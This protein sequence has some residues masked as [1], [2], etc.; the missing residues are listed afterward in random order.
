MKRL[1]M[2]ATFAL[3]LSIGGVSPAVALADDS[4][5]DAT[6]VQA[7]GSGDAEFP[8]TE[9]PPTDPGE[10]AADSDD[11]ST[12]AEPGD[13]EDST[14]PVGDENAADPGDGEGPADPDEGSDEPTEDSAPIDASFSLDQST[15]PVDEAAEAIPYTITGLKAGDTV[16][17]SPGENGSITVDND[18][19]FNGELRGN[20]EL[21]VGDVVD[22]TVTVARDGQEPKTF[23]GNVEITENQDDSDASVS[24]DPQSQGIDSYLD[25]GVDITVSSC[26]PGEDVT[27]TIVR[28][29]EN[30]NI[31]E[32]T[33]TAGDDGS[34]SASF[35]PGTGGDGWIGEFVVR[36]KCGDTTAET[37]YS[38]TE[39]ED[40]D[41]ADLSITPQS[42]KL[43]VF[44]ENGVNITLVN[45]HV[46]SNVKFEVS[47]AKN[48][49]TVIWEE[50]QKAGE[51]AAGSVQFL[52]EGDGGTAW[53]G[54]FNVVAS[55][56]DKSAEATF[57]VTDDGSVVDPKLSISPE[58]IS[59]EDFIDRDQGV[60]LMVNKCVPDA[61]VNF[62][63]WSEGKKEKLYEQTATAN[64]EGAAGIH[65][66]GLGDDPAYYVG[67]YQVIAEC[68]DVS[69][70][71]EF[72]VTG[73]ESGGGDGGD[74]GGAGGSGGGSSMPRTGAELTGLA[75]GA[76]LILG[77]GTA[78]GLARRKNKS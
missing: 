55:C 14:D 23:T 64:E 29:G 33:K 53:V 51:D 34:V 27:V 41:D 63:V 4:S 10:D 38:V 47:S 68:M 2:A 18:G 62:E 46:D 1:A 72:V 58:T 52:P 54:D 75:A 28:K 42:Q 74:S 20:T 22:V 77:G 24:V 76:L 30:T 25:N 5:A 40:G 60:Q 59:G 69:R 44:L 45:C 71:G 19:T 13:G 7:S 48:P 17:A 65:V 12:P 9:D 21:K 36:A 6:V 67:T 11:G 78:I 26:E 15:M 50:T 35:M 57:T 70:S 73:G 8:G 3:A 32:E 39:N 61:D 43:A 16:T 49:D 56:G 37:T 66:Y 31:W